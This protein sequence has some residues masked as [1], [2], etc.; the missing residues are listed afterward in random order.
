MAAVE[1]KLEV[2]DEESIFHDDDHEFMTAKSSPTRPPMPTKTGDVLAVAATN[3]SPE[4]DLPSKGANKILRMQ[5]LV[6]QVRYESK[7]PLFLDLSSRPPPHMGAVIKSF[8]TTSLGGKSEAEKSGLV[9]VGDMVISLNDIDCTVLPFGK[10][11]DEAKNA[12]FPLTLTILSK[13]HIA[14]FFPADPKH[15]RNNSLGDLPRPTT[16]P[17]N[18]W[19]DKIGAIFDTRTKRTSVGAESPAPSPNGSSFVASWNSPPP[20]PQSQLLSPPP[21]P[22]SNFQSKF[23]TWQDS[24]RLEKVSKTTLLSKMILGKRSDERD[25]V[26]ATLV[27]GIAIQPIADASTTSVYHTSAL[28]VVTHAASRTLTRLEEEGDLMFQWFRSVSPTQV[29]VLRGATAESY[30]PS[31][32]DVDALVYVQCHGVCRQDAA[33]TRRKV[34]VYGPIVLDPSIK[35]TVEMVVE[36]G[37]SSFSATLANSDMDNSFQLKL[38]ATGCTLLKIAED[39][40]GIV[41]DAPYTPATHVYLEPSDPLGFVLRFQEAGDIVGKNTDETCTVAQRNLQA[42]HLVAQTPSSRDLIALALR[43]YRS[44]VLSA[45]ETAASRAAEKAYGGDLLDKTLLEHLM[46]DDADEDAEFESLPPALKRSS[47]AKTVDDSADLRRQ[48][49]S[50][51]LVLKATQNERNLLAIAVEVRD[52]KL[53]EAKAETTALQAR[54]DGLV[55]ELATAK[56]AT[57]RSR[58]FEATTRELQ[59]ALAALE[60]KKEALDAALTTSH[61]V[62]CQLEK[63][64]Q[65]AEADARSVRADLVELQQSQVRLI[66]ERNSF[67]AKADGLSKELRRL[68][69]GGRSIADIEA[70]LQD[71]SRLQVELSVAKANIKRYQDEATEFE[72]ALQTHTKRRGLHDADLTRVVGQNAEL[73]RLVAQ[74]SASLSEKEAEIGRLQRVNKVLMSKLPSPTKLQLQLQK[75]TSFQMQQQLVFHDDDEEDDEDDEDD[76]EDDEDDEDESA[77]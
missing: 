57:E 32:D 12:T 75:S 33:P 58:K 21:Q 22:D 28:G 51:A 20:Q 1:G 35:E 15:R 8:R 53:A 48:L 9:A 19:S 18:R 30:Q 2:E 11:I 34:A 68:L 25:D 45:E 71:R 76:E 24:I 77:E 14:E 62:T 40:S 10:I 65:S 72:D 39:E 64:V 52:R 73:Q 3:N 59:Q 69:K 42:I 36:A 41:V 27:R 13:A 17:T 70:Q 47:S 54:V 67:K 50:Q 46:E 43:T 44:R 7:G 6:K 66:E 74:F 38:S 37:A 5:S 49:A 31:L 60:A 63:H 56:I 26:L 29:L 16:P 55:G 61:G 4:I 23:R